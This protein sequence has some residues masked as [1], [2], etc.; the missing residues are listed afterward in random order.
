MDSNFALWHNYQHRA[1]KGMP[2][3]KKQNT[4]KTNTVKGLWLS[5]D[6][7][8]FYPS[9][10]YVF[11]AP[12]IYT[13]HLPSYQRRKTYAKLDKGIPKKNVHFFI[14][15]VKKFTTPCLPF[16]LHQDTKNKF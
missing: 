7:P 6:F 1:I 4:L 15:I 16:I 5:W 8:T 13:T 2:L 14:T 10:L 9:L 3:S 11:H 12:T